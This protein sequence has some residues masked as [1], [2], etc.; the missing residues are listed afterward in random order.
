MKKPEHDALEGV[1]PDWI[2]PVVAM[3]VILLIVA[4]ALI[5]VGLW[6]Q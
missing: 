1:I 4:V 2:R 5:A 3:M 6:M